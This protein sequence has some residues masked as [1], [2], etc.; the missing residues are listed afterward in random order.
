MR[1]IEVAAAL[2]IRDHKLLATERGYG[3]YK[4]WWEFPGGKLEPG[5]TGEQAIAREIMEELD[6]EVR[7]GRLYCTV[8]HDY[9]RFHMKMYCYLCELVSDGITLIEHEAARWLSADELDSVQWL[10]SDV[11]IIAQLKE[12]SSI[13]F[14][15]AG[16]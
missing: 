16:V 2:I 12:D 1:N 13:I 11:S 4:D 14:R 3:D 6:A 5:E 7:V 15:Q 10:P 9:P 8:E